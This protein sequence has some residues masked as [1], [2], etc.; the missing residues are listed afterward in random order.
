M[1]MTADGWNC[2]F[3]L[4]ARKKTYVFAEKVVRFQGF[5]LAY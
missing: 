4:M 2:T 3:L 5:F 1:A